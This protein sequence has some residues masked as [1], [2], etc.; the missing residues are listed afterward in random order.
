[1]ADLQAFQQQV[2]Q[3]LHQNEELHRRLTAAEGQVQHQAGQRP[4]GV[5]AS[6]SGGIDTRLVKQPT[7]FDG[8]RAEWSDWSFT[9]RAFSSAIGPK[10]AELMTTA[11]AKGTEPVE[12]PTETW[13]RS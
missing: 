10:M 1:M 2:Q 5:A 13:T 4:A 8:T 6:S 7:T 3:L 12:L 9:F 11:E